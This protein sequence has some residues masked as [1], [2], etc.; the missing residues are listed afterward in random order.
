MAA[1]F[2]CL[3]NPPISLPSLPEP[4]TNNAI[5]IVNSENRNYLLSFNGLLK[6]K[7]HKSVSNKAFMLRVGDK[8]WQGI[9]NVP[10]HQPI[11][12]LTG[13]LASVATSIKDNAYIFGGYTVAK[14]HS[15]VS[16]P[17][18]YSFN[19]KTQKYTLLAPMP[20]PVDDSIA[21]TYQDRFIYLVSGWHNDGNVNLVQI[22]D[23]KTNTWQQASPFPG[24][25]VF[26][27]AGAIVNNKMLICDG[28]RVDVHLDKRRSYAAEPA[29][30]LGSISLKQPNKINWH[31]VAHPTGV[32]RYRMAAT[33]VYSANSAYF[34]G[35]SDNPYN[36]SG[37]GYN[38]APSE[39][40]SKIWKFDFN[41]NKWQLLTSATATM[42][43]RS[44]IELNN[45]LYTVGGM[46]K[47]QE[48][49]DK[50]I[51]QTTITP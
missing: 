26:G 9:N 34:I 41:S 28:V 25:P 21:L 8:S 11:N 13:R 35:G 31:K 19:V 16:V 20:V 50:V 42:D 10:I 14:D 39:P 6:G 36:Y 17:D 48:V 49:T 24:K 37:I 18:V 12:G 45:T 51:A 33:G 1:S 46:L 40:D 4:I 32:A 2:T 38:G 15:E 29:C 7:D 44:L 5:T 3:A 23:T 30:Y 47:A 43:H 22:Y 27:Q